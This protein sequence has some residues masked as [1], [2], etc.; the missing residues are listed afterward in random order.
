MSTAAASNDN[1][2]NTDEETATPITPASS[3]SDKERDAIAAMR[4]TLK[5]DPADVEAWSQLGQAYLATGNR[6]TAQAVANELERL[7]PERATG[8]RQQAGMSAPPAADSPQNATKPA[9]PVAGRPA[10]P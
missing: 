6:E 9:A 8:L 5:I 1:T 2:K 3:L 4:H 7:D 10:S